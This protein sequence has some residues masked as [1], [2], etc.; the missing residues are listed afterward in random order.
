L[1]CSRHNQAVSPASTTKTASR[2]QAIQV[3][4][5]GGLAFRRVVGTDPGDRRG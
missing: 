2:S 5:F 1:T 4:A 3:L